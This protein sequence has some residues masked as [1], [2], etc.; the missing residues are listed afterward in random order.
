MDINKLFD[1]SLALLRIEA[2]YFSRLTKHNL[3]L[4]R[5]NESH[6]VNL[7][8]YHLPPKIGIG[9]GFIACGGEKPRQS[10]QCDI[11]LYDALNNFHLYSSEAWSIYPIE[12]VYGVIEVKT[13]LQLA[14]LK[15][16]FDKCSKIRSMS[17]SSGSGNKR[18]LR[19]SPQNS[20]EFI[21]EIS[22]LPPRFFI[23]SYNGWHRMKFLEK[24]FYDVSELYKEA[25]IHGLCCLNKKSSLFVQHVPHKKG[26]EKIAPGEKVNGF[27]YFMMSLPMMINAM[28]PP[29]RLVLGFDQV[30]LS[31][32]GLEIHA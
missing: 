11:I 12:M 29:H 27:R 2:E 25:H 30:D 21:T 20:A 17:G 5:L 8:R 19:Q 31:H 22:D 10:P 7:L 13:T 14:E 32:Y 15:D 1:G 6:L 18:Y 24:H 4:G 26:L 28:L 3:E 9:T 23:F 16:A